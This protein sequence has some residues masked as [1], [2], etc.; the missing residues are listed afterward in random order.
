LILLQSLKTGP[1]LL[2]QLFEVQPQL[3]GPCVLQTAQPFSQQHGGSAPITPFQ[4]QMGHSDLEDPLQHLAAGALSFM[5]E[6][7]KAV[8]AGVPLAGIKKPD[9]FPETGID[10]QAGFF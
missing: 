9:G 10:H 8:V 1:G 3:I 6:L 5:P 4:M 7:L 2:P